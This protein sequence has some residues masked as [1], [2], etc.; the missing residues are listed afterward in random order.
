MP[1]LVEVG[2]IIEFRLGLRENLRHSVNHSQKKKGG[3]TW[4]DLI[5][6]EIEVKTREKNCKLPYRSSQLT[7][8]EGHKLRVGQ[9]LAD[10]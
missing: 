1:M 7:R 2:K 6:V 4:I 10:S 5:Q 8:M 3:M 9:L